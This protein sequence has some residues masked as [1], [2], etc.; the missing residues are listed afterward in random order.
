[1][2]RKVKPSKLLDRDELLRLASEGKI[3]NQEAEAKVAEQGAL[4]FERQPSLPAFDPMHKAQWSLVMSIVWIAW[5][6]L[7]RVREQDSEFQ[8]E[9][10]RWR[11]RE[12][13]KLGDEKRRSGW[14]LEPGSKATVAWL[15]VQEL[16]LEAKDKIPATCQIHVRPAQEVL[17]RALAEGRLIG[18]ALNEAGVPVDIPTRDWSYLQ[19]SPESEAD[20]LNYASQNGRPA[21]TQVKFNREDLF[22]LWP[23][24]THQR[25]QLDDNHIIDEVMIEPLA[26]EGS[27]GFVPLCT[28]LH[29]I[30]TRAGTL[31]LTIDDQEAWDSACEKLFPLI[32]EGT[33]EIVG[34]ASVNSLAEKIPGHSLALAKIDR[35]L[36]MSVDAILSNEAHIWCTAYAGKEHWQGGFN[37]AVHLGG[38]STPVWTHLQVP[39]SEILSRWPRPQ[40]QTKPESDC[41][42]WL[43]DLMRQSPT[44]RPKLKTAL[45]T[46]A[47]D[48][49]TGL[50]ARQFDRAWDKALGES[51]A[52]AWKRPGPR[53]KRSDQGTN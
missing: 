8:S 52:V 53:A 48:K 47:L 19:L 18:H 44:R 5:R 29:W 20:I 1:M 2:T 11:F 43:F 7:S 24:I 3:T 32:H 39:K 28:A 14:F 31:R 16:V 27:N 42:R 41:Y 10:W 13:K 51:G 38:R 35:P 26:S 46:E 6:D 4:P 9:C 15:R 40:S 12:S 17:W 21:F 33:I 36:N 25:V 23:P 45:M 34:R 50:K 37:D 22:A 49:F 30:M